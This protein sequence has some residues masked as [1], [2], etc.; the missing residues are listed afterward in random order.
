MELF[1]QMREL[2][3]GLYW[4]LYWS[5]GRAQSAE[6]RAAG[7][8]E[9]TTVKFV[10]QE[11]WRLAARKKKLTDTQLHLPLKIH[12]LE[13]EVSRFA[14]R[15]GSIGHITVAPVGTL[16]S[17]MNGESRTTEFDQ[18]RWRPWRRLRPKKFRLWPYWGIS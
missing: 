16:Y 5:P 6:E 12:F 3:W 8:G 17:R 7:K 14:Q 9:Q 18:N 11:K 15:W 10:S 1:W 13:V 2:H 4:E